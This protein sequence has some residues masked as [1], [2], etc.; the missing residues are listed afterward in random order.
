VPSRREGR[1][2]RKNII[3][4]HRAILDA[5][6]SGETDCRALIARSSRV[7]TPPQRRLENI[8]HRKT[9]EVSNRFGQELCLID[10]ETDPPR[11]RPTDGNE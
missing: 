5:K 7:P 2:G 9:D 8:T 4:Q 1:T 11:K 6:R 3:H 10:P